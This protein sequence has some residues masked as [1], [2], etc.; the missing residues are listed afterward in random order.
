MPKKSKQPKRATTAKPT[1]VPPE[2]MGRP[3]GP[4]PKSER[5]LV[6]FSRRDRATFEAEVQRLTAATGQ[7]WTVSG[8]LR[9]A[10]LAFV[11]KH[12]AS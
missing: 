9:F 10:G 1:A 6:R 3:P 11:G 8:Y 2:R 5:A 12:L 4:D 7:D